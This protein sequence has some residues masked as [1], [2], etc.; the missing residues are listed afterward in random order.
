MFAKSFTLSASV[1]PKIAD[2]YIIAVPTPLVEN[3]EIF[4]PDISHVLDVAKEICPLLKKGNMIILES[5]S[6]IGTTK[7]IL[8]IFKQRTNVSES[9]FVAYCPERV[10]PGNIIS[11]LVNNDRVVG[12]VNK[13][14][15]RI[16]ADFYIRNSK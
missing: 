15:T 1:E 11:E 8:E 13:E 10:I 4:E 14:S 9:I 16:V 3:K 5:T 7:K 2:V 12:G 6:P